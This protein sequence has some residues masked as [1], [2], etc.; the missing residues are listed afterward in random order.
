MKNKLKFFQYFNLEALIWICGLIILF[1]LHVDGLPHFTICPFK[2]LGIDFCPGCGLG[3]SIHYFLHFEFQ[4]SLQMHPLGIVAFFILLNRII[5]LLK[6][7][8]SKLKI[9]NL[10]GAH[11]E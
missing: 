10:K 1:F 2:S 4:K 6:D 5:F 8:F 11:Y 9:N 3:R 7:N